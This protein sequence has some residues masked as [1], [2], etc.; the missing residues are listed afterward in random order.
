LARGRFCGQVRWHRDSSPTR[1]SPTPF[2]GLVDR[3]AD[4]GDLVLI[5]GRGRA[6]T[7]SR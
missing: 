6:L 3:R 7:K 2:I 1:R 5:A 4:D